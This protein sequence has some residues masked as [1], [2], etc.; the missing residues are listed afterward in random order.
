MPNVGNAILSPKCL[1]AIFAEPVP[2]RLPGDCA[3]KLLR[4]VSPGEFVMAV[5]LS[6]IKGSPKRMNVFRVSASVMPD[7]ANS[8]ASPKVVDGW[9]KRVLTRA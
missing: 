9:A 4:G 3:R 5:C 7:F 8:T 2:Y 6:C 1:Y